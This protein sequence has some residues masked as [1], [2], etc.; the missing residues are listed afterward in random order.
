MHGRE[1]AISSC[2]RQL[3]IPF[4]SLC[5]PFH[6]SAP[7]WATLGLCH[8]PPCTWGHSCS[9]QWDMSQTLLFHR[10]LAALHRGFSQLGSPST[11]MY[12]T[13]AW[14]V[15]HSVPA[16]SL[17][18]LADGGR[19]STGLAYSW[20]GRLIP[21]PLTEQV[22]LAMAQLVWKLPLLTQQRRKRH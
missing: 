11:C 17:P 8:C 16:P 15:S 18:I 20:R 21:S 1:S 7:P 10:S 12:V 19:L 4:R 9:A 6:H 22:L 13:R 3:K 2:F 5:P 14:A